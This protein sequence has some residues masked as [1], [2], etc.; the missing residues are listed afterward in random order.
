MKISYNLR[1]NA[2]TGTAYRQTVRISEDENRRIFRG[3][4]KPGM[5]Y[6]N[7]HTGAYIAHALHGLPEYAPQVARI[8]TANTAVFV[9]NGPIPIY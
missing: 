6:G 4:F 3:V 1:W 8:V 7:A 9:G 5:N 2:E